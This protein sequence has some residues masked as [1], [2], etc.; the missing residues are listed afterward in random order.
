MYY[1]LSLAEIASMSLLHLTLSGAIDCHQLTSRFLR[2]LSTES[3]QIMTVKCFSC[4]ECEMVYAS[5]SALSRHKKWHKGEN[6]HH[7]F[8]CELCLYSTDSRKDFKR[9]SFIHSG[10]RPF[11]CTLCGRGFTR[12][13]HLKRHMLTHSA[14]IPYHCHMCPKSFRRSDLLATHIQKHRDDENAMTIL[15]SGSKIT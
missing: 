7:R 11:T 14:S 4:D 13:N 1:S 3:V 2:S 8:K 12:N 5:N 9:H 6:P 15:T 10:E